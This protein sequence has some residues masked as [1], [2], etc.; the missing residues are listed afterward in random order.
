MRTRDKQSP[1]NRSQGGE[2]LNPDYWNNGEVRICVEKIQK[3]K[4]DTN[5]M[6]VMMMGEGGGPPRIQDV[7]TRGWLG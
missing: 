5:T 2:K 4:N 3:K 7:S 6:M 1:T